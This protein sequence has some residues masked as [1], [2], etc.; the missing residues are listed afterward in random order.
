M[1]IEIIKGKSPDLISKDKFSLMKEKM[2][3]FKKFLDTKET[4]MTNTNDSLSYY[5]LPYISNP[6]AHPS[7][8]N[9][10]TTNWFNDIYS[11]LSFLLKENLKKEKTLIEVLLEDKLMMQREI[12]VKGKKEEHDK[13]LLYESQIKWSKLSLE[14]IKQSNELIIEIE[15]IKDKTNVNITK[16]YSIKDKLKKYQQFINE[17]L[18]ELKKT[19]IDKSKEQVVYKKPF[20][21][22]NAN[23]VTISQPVENKI[24]HPLKKNN[25]KPNTQSNKNITQA[26]NNEIFEKANIEKERPKTQ[27][28]KPNKEIKNKENEDNDTTILTKVDNYND[29]N[30]LSFFK[31][32][33]D[34]SLFI[35]SINND[36]D[37]DS[38]LKAAIKL[39]FV[40]R[41]IRCRLTRKK[42]FDLKQY[43][44]YG[45]IYYDLFGIRP[46]SSLLLNKKSNFD[47][48]ISEP[49]LLV[50]TLKLINSLCNEPKGRNYFLEKETFIEDIVSIMKQEAK[51]TEIRQNCLGIIQKLTLKSSPQIKLI[52]LNMIHWITLILIEDSEEGISEYTLE[53]GLALLMNLSLRKSGRDKCEELARPIL[54]LLAN[55]INSDSV[56]IRTCVN[57]TLY[58]LI[59]R[60]S[61][62][63][64]AKNSQLE[65]ILLGLSEN[66]NDQMKKQIQ[67]ILD[68]LYSEENLEVI[69]EEN[70]DDP[71]EEDEQID[72]EYVSLV[73]IINILD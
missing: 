37:E 52:E 48:L 40:L 57:G 58:S 10:F 32:K 33:E 63:E 49:T 31:I 23:P 27:T 36:N 26:D 14:I 25:E 38:K 60:K 59:K 43:T 2:K 11:K 64:I 8:K 17:N 42:N 16:A 44:L 15:N 72:E 30:L 53:Y 7:F 19:N 41:E 9:L 68:E 4:D 18:D 47:F 22:Q 45:V 3:D 39:N 55:Y 24:I 54:T 34:L 46:N 35:N 13:H 12:E 67:Y 65:N 21:E 6:L 20:V 50:E 62:K 28:N 71:E 56:Q 1:L 51:E 29:D 70:A 61:I 5:A 73:V 69:E 66:P